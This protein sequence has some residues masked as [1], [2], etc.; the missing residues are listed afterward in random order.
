MFIELTVQNPR[1]MSRKNRKVRLLRE[2]YGDVSIKLLTK[3]DIE[4][5]FSNRLARAS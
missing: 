3:R 5:V 4:R 2:T 1:L